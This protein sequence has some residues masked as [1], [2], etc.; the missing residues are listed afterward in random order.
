MRRTLTLSLLAALVAA[1][2]LSAQTLVLGSSRAQ[3]CYESTLTQATSRTAI[4]TCQTAIN[5]DTLS[6]RD[7]AATHSNMGI[8]LARMGRA[9]EAMASYNAAIRIKP[10]LA[11]AYINRASL[12]LDT[13][14]DMAL[15]LEDYGTAI[16][17]GGRDMHIAHLGRAMARERAGDVEGAY[18]D[19]VA[20]LEI[21]PGWERAEQE[22][23]RYTVI[24]GNS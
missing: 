1:P 22:L 21:R 2:S 4:A 19:L 24:R 14:A 10:D 18:A 20:A 16:E 17:L 15:S 11:A 23:S 5:E 9:D 8:L 7:R 13:G 3:S 12:R 6:A